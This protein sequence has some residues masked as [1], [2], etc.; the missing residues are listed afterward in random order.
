MLECGTVG[1]ILAEVEVRIQGVEGVCI[2]PPSVALIL[3]GKDD[4]LEA[5]E[6]WLDLIERI[7]TAK[8]AYIVL[9]DDG[10]PRHYTLVE[11]HA[12]DEGL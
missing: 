8:H 4:S 12:S 3:A 5:N 10:P 2:V 6:R 9:H 1:A 7:S 11:I